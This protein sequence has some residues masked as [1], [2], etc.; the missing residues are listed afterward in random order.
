MLDSIDFHGLT[1]AGDVVDHVG[2]G[3]EVCGLCLAIS[4]SA[5]YHSTVG[6]VRACDGKRIFTVVYKMAIQTLYAYF[7]QTGLQAGEFLVNLC[8]AF[9][10][11]V[12][13]HVFPFTTWS[14]DSV[15]SPVA[16]QI[17]ISVEFGI[18]DIVGG[19]NAIAFSSR[20][21]QCIAFCLAD[22]N[23]LVVDIVGIRA[24]AVQNLGPV[25][26]GVK[27]ADTVSR[28]GRSSVS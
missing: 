8:V 22:E 6:L 16:L 25:V 28:Y 26:G 11:S 23:P 3:L 24:V 21:E 5:I 15:K 4:V 10:P 9:I 20:L 18:F 14:F 7:I 2:N 27:C 13:C 1:H 12:T 17:M 19:I